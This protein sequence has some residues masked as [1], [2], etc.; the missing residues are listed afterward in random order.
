MRVQ[1]GHHFKDRAEGGVETGN[2]DEDDAMSGRASPSHYIGSGSLEALPSEIKEQICF[3]LDPQDR[4]RFA[5]CSRSLRAAAEASWRDLRSL[6]V[7]FNT[8]KPTITGAVSDPTAGQEEPSG[9]NIPMRYSVVFESRPREP[10]PA[11]QV[12]WIEK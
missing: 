9:S 7:V 4:Y 1:L 12:G 5:S 2:A 6:N 11:V 8:P 3:E 10:P